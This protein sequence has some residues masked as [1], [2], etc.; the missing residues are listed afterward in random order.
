MANTLQRDSA[1]GGWRDHALPIIGKEARLGGGAEE[2][3]R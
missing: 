2:E 3:L 1:P